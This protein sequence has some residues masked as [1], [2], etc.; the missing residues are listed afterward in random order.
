MIGKVKTGKSFYH[1]ISYCLEDKKA[2][3][4]QDKQQR[5][6]DE[7][8]Q[9]KDRAEVLEYNLCYGD[10]WALT[11]QF[12][13]VGRLSKRVEKPLMH[14]SIRA[15][16]GDQLTQEQWREIGQEAARE[17]GLDKHQ[18]ICVLHK[19]TKQPHIHLV[20]NRV[21]LDGKV[22]SDSNSYARIAALC[23]RLE[24]KYQ[25]KTVLSPRR[26]LSE[27]E[28]R[29]PRHDQRKLRLKEKIQDALK[30]SRSW[31]EFE[32][33]IREQGYRVDKG[34]GIAFEDDK[35]VRI[36]GS[37]VGYSLSTIERVLARNAQIPLREAPDDQQPKQ[38]IQ[39]RAR[40]VDVSDKRRTPIP[41]TPPPTDSSISSEMSKSMVRALEAM[42]KVEPEQTAGGGFDPWEEEIR[43]RK[44]KKKRPRI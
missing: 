5:P 37:E 19:D 40:Q 6:K 42:L 21:G 8:L 2:L 39:R 11:E 10:K 27:K 44:K 43:R 13:E 24:K 28:R 9:H 32:Q 3:S 33:K 4:E 23:R 20:A 35:K 31:P 14:L 34:R 7:G 30:D 16:P 12:R 29:I 17:F 36:K 26:F 15:A 25:L 41:A 18:Y 38:E 22:A 1:C